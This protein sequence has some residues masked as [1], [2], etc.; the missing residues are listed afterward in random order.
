M[1]TLTPTLRRD[2]ATRHILLAA[3]LGLLSSGCSENFD[4]EYVPVLPIGLLIGAALVFWQHRSGS[5]PLAYSRAQALRG[6][7]MTPRV[8]L[9]F[10]PPVLRALAFIAVVIACARPQWEAMDEREVEGIDIFLVL[11]MSGSMAAIDLSESEAVRIQRATNALPPNRFDNAIGTLK[12]FVTAR[13]RDRIGMVVFARDAYL[14]FPLTLDYGTILTLLDRLRLEAIDASA[15]AIGNALGLGVRGL[16]DS[17]AASRAIILITDGKQQ[18]GNISP[19][20]AAELAEEEGI[21][22]YSILVGQSGS[23]LIP[24]NLQNRDGT[25]R[26]R[27]QDYPV[28]PELL[29]EIAERT[30]GSFYRAEQPEQL[31]RDLNSILDELERTQ[32]EDVSSV[33]ERELFALFC[34]AALMLLLLDAFLSWLVI[35]RLP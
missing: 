27:S 2:L 5:V 12:N 18:G 14:Q 29:Q 26:L 30:G 4:L 35:R 10:V 13:E 20:R 16:F 23:A 34:I 22:I 8:A 32:R 31:E 7:P 33:L 15:T 1:S 21:T 24:T 9:R 17:E 28:D 25:R 6:L 19:R 3:L 11:D